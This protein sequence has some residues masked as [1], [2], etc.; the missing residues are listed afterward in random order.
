[1]THAPLQLRQD[2]ARRQQ[3]LEAAAL[4]AGVLKEQFG[5]RQVYLFGSL[6]GQ[7]PWHSRSDIDLAVEGLD[8]Q[9]YFSAL[10][11]L[12]QLL[13]EGLELDL[14]SLEE[15]PPELAAR[16][17]GEVAMPD[18]PKTAL[19]MDIKDELAS[20]E[21]IADQAKTLLQTLSP[22]PT[23]I[24]I[25]AAGKLA[26]DFY[27]GAER[28]FERI[29]TRLGPGLPTGAGWH[30]L[31]LRSLER[32]AEGIRPAV[33]TH[34]LA[35]HLVDYLGFRHVFRHSYGYELQWP[36]FSHLI[37]GLAETQEQLRRQLEQFMEWL[38][39]A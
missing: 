25:S 5:A 1:M 17:K 6:T 32:E 13:P 28:I 27:S 3:A 9:K 31:L 30:V 12:L 7:S 14:V 24:E 8:P 23:F 38:S 11:A 37:E 2:E 34:E 22:E 4:C 20:L 33:I 16:I 18:D 29:A 36:R 39:Q 35:L 21:R 10:G 15:A 26:H 19:S